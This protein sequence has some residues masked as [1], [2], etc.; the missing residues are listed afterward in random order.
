[1]L[2]IERLLREAKFDY[3]GGRVSHEVLDD[4]MKELCKKYGT[5]GE[6]INAGLDSWKRVFRKGYCFICDREYGSTART[7][8]AHIST[9][10][11][12]VSHRVREASA[13]EKRMK[14]ITQASREIE[15]AQILSKYSDHFRPAMERG[16]KQPGRTGYVKKYHCVHCDIKYATNLGAMAL[17][18]ERHINDDFIKIGRTRTKEVKDS[19]KTRGGLFRPEDHAVNQ[20]GV[21]FFGSDAIFHKIVIPASCKREGVKLFCRKCDVFSV[22]YGDD[23]SEKAKCK[24]I[25]KMRRHEARCSGVISNQR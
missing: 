11:A 20:W 2:T 4:R 16:P 18:S 3:V 22:I 13:A 15:E 10:H 19:S 9:V 21:N 1:M 25:A 12:P 23:L 14:N 7:L 6:P 24:R 8:T 5:D 17:H